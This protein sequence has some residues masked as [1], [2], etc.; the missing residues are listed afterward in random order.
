MWKKMQIQAKNSSTQFRC[1]WLLAVNQL[2]PLSKAG[3]CRCSV[4]E[5][6]M[7]A[8]QCLDVMVTWLET[9]RKSESLLQ[10]G[11]VP[12]NLMGGDHEGADPWHGVLLYGMRCCYML[13]GAAPW[14]RVLLYG[15]GC[16][17]MA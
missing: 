3:S 5:S 8:Q 11:S 2:L 13:W 17:F 15:M 12:Q 9:R 6:Q 7:T 4:F 16:C 14:H 10:N 1:S